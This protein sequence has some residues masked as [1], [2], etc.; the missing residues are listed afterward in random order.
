M[1]IS[2]PTFP[3]GKNDG[4]L[5]WG[6]RVVVPPRGR[7]EVMSILHVTHAGESR[8]KSLARGYIWWPGI[9]KEIEEPAKNC[10]VRQKH[11]KTPPKTLCTLGNGLINL[12]PEYMLIILDLSWG[13]CSC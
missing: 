3:E 4:C 1:R 8:M 13:R 7:K 2:S 11:Q 5:L 12:G 10:I 6:S 9:D